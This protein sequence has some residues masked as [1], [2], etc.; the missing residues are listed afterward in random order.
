MYNEYKLNICLSRKLGF[1][2]I[3]FG[4]NI[5]KMEAGEGEEQGLMGTIST[6]IKRSQIPLVW[7]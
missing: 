4:P 6:C 7:T 5:K 2:L 1:H 3:Q